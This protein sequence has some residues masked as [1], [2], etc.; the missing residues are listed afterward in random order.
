MSHHTS[1]TSGGLPGDA[2]HPPARTPGVPAGGEPSD[3][4][5]TSPDHSVASFGPYKL[6]ELLGEGGFGVVWLAEQTEPVRRRVAIK[7]IKPGMDSKAVIARFGAERQAL[8]M[9]S[10]PN[11][12]K[13]LDAGTTPLTAAGG[14]RPYFVMEHVKGSPITHYCDTHRLTIDQRLRLFSQVCDAV[15]HAHMKGVIHRD[16]KPSNIL[17]T[18]AESGEPRPVIIDF[19]VAKALAGR[20]TDQTIYTERGMMI[21]TLEYMSP[22]QAE[23]A[24]T[25]IDTRTDIYSLGVVLYELLAGSAPIES[26]TLRTAGFGGA[27]RM[28]READP[29]RPSAR[30]LALGAS[31]S[32]IAEA[33]GTTGPALVA[34][35]RRELEW[36]PLKALR[37][38]RSERYRSASELGD[39]I[40]NYLANR[41][42]IAGPESTTYKMRKFVRRNRGAAAAA[43]AIGASLVLATGVSVWFGLRERAA[44]QR[45]SEQ[46]I[47]AERAKQRAEDMNAFMTKAFRSGDPGAGGRQDTTIA[48]AMQNAIRELDSGVFK[49]DPA[50]EAGL[51]ETI[52]TI[53]L[54]NGKVMDSEPQFAEVL[55]IRRKQAV[56]DERAIA[57]ALNNLAAVKRDLGK[58]QDA[59]ALATEALDIRRRIYKSDHADLA[60]SLNTLAVL[61]AGMGRHAEA[62]ALDTESLEMR[63]RMYKG[64]HND[65]ASSLNSLGSTK[66]AL[67]RHQEAE[68]LYTESLEM[69][70]R[71]YK[72]DHPSVALSLNNV[73]AARDAMGRAAEAEPLYVE[74]LEMR[75]RMFKGDH[76]S[77]ANSLNN[78]A[79]VRSALGRKA[80]AEPLF[81][82]ALEMNRRMFKGDHPRVAMG[83]NNLGQLRVDQDRLAEAEPLLAESLEMSRRI[84]KGDH[85]EV[86]TGLLNLAALRGRDPARASETKAGY[87]EAVAMLRRLSPNGSAALAS[88]LWKSGTWKRANGDAGGGLS[89]LKEAV[90]VGER[91]LPAGHKDLEKY[92]EAVVAAR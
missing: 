42:L 89:E 85:P 1:E 75:R 18:V 16:L 53:L 34:C 36:I 68:A 60:L 37:K 50:S 46:R 4:A 80:E 33:R 20:L 90:E 35:L 59:E 92:R 12:A 63:R 15:Q 55:S 27:Q 6:L 45:E 8:A 56:P 77:V 7:V 19:G 5:W 41:P 39:D 64:D 65:I 76:P 10:H 22:E 23:M 86:V 66:E 21:G 13:V 51:R 11:I 14:G 9:M 71:L 2:G 54:S 79:F 61:R 83:L 62:E 30:L 49:E 32:A 44:L 82:E 67:G 72:G 78:L 69:K 17:V 28:I 26:A 87:D 47:A 88:A 52:A 73:A 81:V 91:V 40:D 43:T 3:Q 29:P 70:R 25:D 58:M 74:A 38:D 48:Q 24:E 31:N 84:H 57:S